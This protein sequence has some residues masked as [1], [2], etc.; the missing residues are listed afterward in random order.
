MLYATNCLANDNHAVE[1]LILGDDEVD[2]GVPGFGARNIE[3]A[4]LLL[5]NRRAVVTL[6][7]VSSLGGCV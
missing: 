1:A 7:I 2:H 5:A 6:S 4:E 3:A